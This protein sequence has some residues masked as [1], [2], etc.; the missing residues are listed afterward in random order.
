MNILSIFFDGVALFISLALIVASFVS[1]SIVW[2]RMIGGE[3]RKITW[4]GRLFLFLA[5]SVGVYEFGLA[6]LKQLHVAINPSWRDIGLPVSEVALFVL[7]LSLA[8]PFIIVSI[9]DSWVRRKERAEI[10]PIISICLILIFLYLMWETTP[11]I[12]RKVLT[13]FHDLK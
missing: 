4:S 3:S 13:L 12:T 5:G 8:V 9:R 10:Q 2:G 1:T 11:T 6:I 7:F